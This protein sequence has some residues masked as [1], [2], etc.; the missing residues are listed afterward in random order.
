M[1]T[2]LAL[3][4]FKNEFNE[5]SDKALSQ[6]LW[7]ID[8]SHFLTDIQGN[9]GKIYHCQLEMGLNRPEFNDFLEKSGQEFQNN[10]NF[11]SEQPCDLKKKF[12]SDIS[13]TFSITTES[14]TV[15]LII[16]APIDWETYHIRYVHIDPNFRR[17]GL[18]YIFLEEIFNILKQHS[19]KRIET[20]SSPMN[21]SS[22]GLC[23]KLG[24]IQTGNILSDRWGALI[25][26]TKFLD[27]KLENIF[28]RQFVSIRS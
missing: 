16:S 15:G 25:K 8:W 19:I 3:K 13:D 22:I 26:W 4:K 27:K 12:Y 9:S 17:E 6:I 11:E 18:S 5:Q 10:Q 14:K 1:R 2:H 24:F 7:G 23:K 28:F 21:R 20:E